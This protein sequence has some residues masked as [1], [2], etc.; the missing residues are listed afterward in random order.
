MENKI[1]NM[2]D[3]TVLKATTTKEDV[4]K[5]CKEAKENQFF[6]VCIN[7]THI[8][9]TKKMS[10]S[11]INQVRTSK[12]RIRRIKCKGMYSYRIPSRS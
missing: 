7:P 11:L 5:V 4:V 9:K 3:H 12:K 2:I 1:A 6:S 10:I 8:E